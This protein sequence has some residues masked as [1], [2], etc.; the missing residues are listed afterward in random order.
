MWCWN[1]VKEYTYTTWIWPTYPMPEARSIKNI[2]IGIIMSQQS[3]AAEVHFF[4]LFC[5]I[6]W[7][8]KHFTLNNKQIADKF[9]AAYTL[10]GDQIIKMNTSEIKLKLFSISWVICYQFNVLWH[11]MWLKGIFNKLAIFLLRFQLNFYTNE[12]HESKNWFLM[13]CR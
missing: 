4:I 6:A 3:Y 8:S 9:I 7:L 13:W 12:T 5:W 10:N 2:D 11:T 1:G